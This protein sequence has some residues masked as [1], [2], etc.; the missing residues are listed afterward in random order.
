THHSSCS[1]STQNMHRMRRHVQKEDVH[2][3][4]DVD[5]LENELPNVNPSPHPNEASTDQNLN[6]IQNTDSRLP[7]SESEMNEFQSSNQA[8]S[9]MHDYSVEMETILETL[10]E[11]LNAS[12]GKDIIVIRTKDKTPLC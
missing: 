3:L 5:P 1:F 11:K 10:V 9:S 2:P 7:T 4:G 12:K 8:S 6:H